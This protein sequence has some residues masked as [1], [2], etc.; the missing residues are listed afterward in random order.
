MNR[1]AVARELLA[2]A[3]EL[4]GMEFPTQDAMDKYLKEHPDA[5]KSNHRVVETKKEGPAKKETTKPSLLQERWSQ[6]VDGETKKGYTYRGDKADLPIPIQY[7]A[8]TG[9]SIPADVIFKNKDGQR[10]RLHD[11]VEKAKS[12]K[13][14]REI[15]DGFFEAG[16]T[17][18]GNYNSVPPKTS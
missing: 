2:M 18:S 14:V 5:D 11:D 6:D 3:R 7:G 1:K 10:V 9:F 16:G 12:K 17:V 8:V 13:R 15:L 4:V